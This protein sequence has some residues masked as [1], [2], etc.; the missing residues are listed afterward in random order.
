MTLLPAIPTAASVSAYLDGKPV[1]RDG[2]GE[3]LDLFLD[4]PDWPGRMAVV[5][6]WF[7][8]A[9]R[10]GMNTGHMVLLLSAMF[11]QRADRDIAA[12]EQAVL[13]RM[14]VHAV[15]RDAASRFLAATPDPLAWAHLYPGVAA[16]ALIHMAGEV[17]N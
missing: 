13:Y 7:S 10:C 4:A 8:H 3:H 16:V 14:S 1:L 9:V 12:V 6:S 15:W 5:E 17:V 2:I 11:E